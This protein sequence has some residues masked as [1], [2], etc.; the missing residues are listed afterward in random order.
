MILELE[1]GAV[2][3][4]QTVALAMHIRKPGQVTTRV[5]DSVT[6]PVTPTAASH[7]EGHVEI[8]KRSGDRWLAIGHRHA[9]HADVH[10]ALAT[11]GLAI[12]HSDGSVEEGRQ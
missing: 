7:S 8:V 5:T 2:L 1:L 12:R 10:E 9:D 3:A 6:H 4:V 11:P